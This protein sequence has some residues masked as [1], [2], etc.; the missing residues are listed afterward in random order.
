M[1]TW[2]IIG[3]CVQVTWMV[4]QRI[5]IRSSTFKDLFDLVFRTGIFGMLYV[6]GSILINIILWPLALIINVIIAAKPERL[7]RLVDE[8]EKEEP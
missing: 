3:V 5:F 2:L 4:Y 8:D 1:I 7:E 6:I